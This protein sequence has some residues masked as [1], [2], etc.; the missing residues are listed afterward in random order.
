MN[1]LSALVK[2]SFDLLVKMCWMK[3]VEKETKKRDKLK[4]E[5]ELQEYVVNALTKRCCEIYG[6]GKRDET[7][8]VGRETEYE[9][10]KEGIRHE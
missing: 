7:G 3:A 5:L 8:T 1:Q 10:E 2:E 4:C 6:I 9:Y